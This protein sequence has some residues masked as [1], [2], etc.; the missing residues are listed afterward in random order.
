MKPSSIPLSAIARFSHDGVVF[1]SFNYLLAA[2]VGSL[3][4]VP[5]ALASG[6]FSVVRDGCPVPWTEALAAVDTPKSPF[7]KELTAE[8]LAYLAPLVAS[9]FPP[10]AWGQDSISLGADGQSSVCRVISADGV[11]FCWV[12]ND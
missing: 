4:A 6:D 8:R 5:V 1:R 7:F 9:L 10:H 3:L 12:P 2:R 11:V